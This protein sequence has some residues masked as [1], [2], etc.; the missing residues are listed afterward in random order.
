VLF[1]VARWLLR[2]AQLFFEAV[3]K[4]HVALSGFEPEW[5]IPT[6][7]ILRI[8]AIAFAL[9]VAYPYIPGSV[10]QL[11]GISIFLGIMFSSARLRSSR[12]SSPATR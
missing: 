9:V 12:T 10:R 7:R 2:L 11:Q 5:A 4:G 8:V 3:A 6:F 1:L